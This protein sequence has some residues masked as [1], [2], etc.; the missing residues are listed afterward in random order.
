MA[1]RRAR[2]R[3]PGGA[4]A[5]TS[6]G[7][8]GGRDGDDISSSQYSETMTPGNHVGIYRANSPAVFGFCF[9]LDLQ[10]P[11]RSTLRN[12]GTHRL[13]GVSRAKSRA[14]F[15]VSLKPGEPSVVVAFVGQTSQHVFG[16][17]SPLAD[18]NQAGS[19]PRSP[20]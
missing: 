13:V 16:V 15:W 10:F 11:F 12:H 1:P 8:G 7:E 2:K 20:V 14:V 4:S 9:P 18:E 5:C 3:A 6:L 19:S 17:S